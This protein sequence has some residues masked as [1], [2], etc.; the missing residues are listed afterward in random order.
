MKGP[1]S[2]EK[3]QDEQGIEAVSKKGYKTHERLL[4][5]WKKNAIWTQ[6]AI[7]TAEVEVVTL[8]QQVEPT[9][10][11]GNALSEET[12][13]SLYHVTCSS[14]NRVGGII[15]SEVGGGGAEH[16]QTHACKLPQQTGEAGRPVSKS[17]KQRR[18]KPTPRL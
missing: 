11:R 2:T 7:L 13:A 3:H 9:C 6:V 14:I 17:A 5:S 15:K 12:L 10:G 16:S 8:G 4:V 1:H 18:R